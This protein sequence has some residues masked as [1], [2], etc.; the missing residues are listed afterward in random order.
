MRTLK[1]ITPKIDVRHDLMKNHIA[2]EGP[3]RVTQFIAVSNSYGGQTGTVN[4]S[5]AS[6]DIQPPSADTVVDRHIRVKYFVRVQASGTFSNN[7]GTSNPPVL[8][9]P[10]QFPIASVTD[11]VQLSINGENISDNVSEKLHA[12]LCYGNTA[13]DRRRYWS[14]APSM[15][16][17]YQEYTDGALYGSGRDPLQPSGALEIDSGRSIM[18]DPSQTNN[19][20]NLY[21]VVT[22]PLF[23]SPLEQGIGQESEGFVHIDSL[24]FTVRFRP[25][26]ARFMSCKSTTA[27]GNLSVSFYRPPEMHLNFLT[28]DRNIPLP[29]IQTL[30]YFKN[31]SYVQTGQ[32]AL[33]SGSSNVVVLDSIR[34]SSIPKILY[35]FAAH[36]RSS[37]D[38][39][40]S[41]AFLAIDRVDITFENKSGLLGTATPE[42]LYQISVS[43]G[44][45]L[46]WEQFHRHKGSVVALQF[47]KDIGLDEGLAPGVRGNYSIQVTVTL[48]NPGINA[49]TYEM[50]Q[51]YQMV[52]TLEVSKGSARATIGNLMASEVLR[53][54]SHGLTYYDIYPSLYGGS[55][56]SSIKHIVNTIGQGAKTVA[57]G[58]TSALPVAR[59]IASSLAPEFLPAVEGAGRVAR[60]FGGGLSTGGSLKLRPRRR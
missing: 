36:D 28:V 17:G 32:Q 37:R 30:P 2:L 12:M 15:P 45:N 1:I 43:N 54:D 51:S 46:T 13:L 39:K 41:D 60:E 27:S 8:E 57:K 25:T 20:T 34:L 48:R 40:T 7:N 23:L 49:F 10:R 59:S 18:P 5:Q 22:E 56:W 47:G 38:Q 9:A 52:G 29:M 19:G 4:P 33:T 31:L 26:W 35:L 6:W 3:S 53:A 42:D 14:E 44:C 24:N 21:Y 16:D 55:F 58:V 50:W 11:S